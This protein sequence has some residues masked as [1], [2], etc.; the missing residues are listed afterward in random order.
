MQTRLSYKF[1][2]HAPIGLHSVVLSS[3]Q[4]YKCALGAASPRTASHE[5]P[6][7]SPTTGGASS[8][9]LER[10]A[11]LQGGLTSSRACAGAPTMPASLPAYSLAVGC[12]QLIRLL[13]PAFRDL[14]TQRW[15]PSLCAISRRPP[16]EQQQPTTR[17]TTWVCGRALREPQAGW[18]PACPHPPPPPALPPRMAQPVAAGQT[19][20]CAL[21]APLRPAWVAGGLL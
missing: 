7:D 5:L 16:F 19:P 20:V 14:H 11:A 1:R 21:A 4:T 9:A 2:E 10:G 3:L 18:L 17:C 8:N 12:P 6:R 13:K 15:S